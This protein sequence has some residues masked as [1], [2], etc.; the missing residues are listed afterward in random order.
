MKSATAN[1]NRRA[2]NASGTARAASHEQRAGREQHHSQDGV[3]LDVGRVRQPGV[4][5]PCPP[6]RADHQEASHQPAPGG[7]FEPQRRHLR[8]RE[9]E[10]EVEEKLDCRD[11]M[12][13]VGEEAAHGARLTERDE[14]VHDD[15]HFFERFMRSV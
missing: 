1:T 5:R 11:F 13:A 2:P 7:L 3:G 9:H 4:A 15:G 10:H 6:Q 12:L 14:E 8:E